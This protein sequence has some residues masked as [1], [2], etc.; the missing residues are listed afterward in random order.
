MVNGRFAENRIKP[1]PTASGRELRRPRVREGDSRRHGNCGMGDPSA[2]HGL[3]SHGR[4]FLTKTA[5][6][7]FIGSND[8]SGEPFFGR[9]GRAPES[10]FRLAGTGHD[11]GPCRDLRSTR[12]GSMGIV[13]GDPDADGI[14][15]FYITHL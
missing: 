4:V 13:V 7:D 1:N 12:S 6:L 10:R 11:S 9:A 15:N 5:G 3:G 2:G 8:M 14:P